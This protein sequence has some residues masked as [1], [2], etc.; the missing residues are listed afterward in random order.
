ML[1]GAGVTKLAVSGG[2]IVLDGTIEVLSGRTW[3]ASKIF[4]AGEVLLSPKGNLSAQQITRQGMPAA[5]NDA[6][7]GSL[8]DLPNL[9]STAAGNL[10]EKVAKDYFESNGFTSLDGKCGANNCFDGVYIKGD[11][12]VINEVKPLKDNGSI[13]LSSNA[14]SSTLG[15]QMSPDWIESRIN[16]LKGSGDPAKVQTAN[17]IQQAIKN[18]NLVKLVSG[19]NS[20]GMT[21]IKLK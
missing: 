8:K 16:E 18:G 10:R 12:V 20:S 6:A 2:K 11:K 13:S 14:G 15:V 9:D 1:A 19:V 5:L 4:N 7:K 3:E 21:M 17:I